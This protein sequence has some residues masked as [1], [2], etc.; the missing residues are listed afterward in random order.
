MKQA[1]SYWERPDCGHALEPGGH[2]ILVS[3]SG[4]GFAANDLALDPELLR[5]REL[6]RPVRKLHSRSRP[7]TALLA[8]TV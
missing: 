5:R 4:E 3:V 8:V 2:V 7:R 6:Q 1:A